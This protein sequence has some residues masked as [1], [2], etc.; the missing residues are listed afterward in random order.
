MSP[1]GRRQ[2]QFGAP[3]ISLA[4]PH[5][6]LIV[7]NDLLG[8]GEDLIEQFGRGGVGV[9]HE[10]SHGLRMAAVFHFNLGSC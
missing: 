4:A 6:F 7:R 10:H 3:M 9:D 5:G 8:R 2:L 1:L